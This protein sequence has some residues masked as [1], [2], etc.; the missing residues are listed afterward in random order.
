MIARFA[1]HFKP[2]IAQ[3]LGTGG[4]FTNNFPSRLFISKGYLF[5]G[6][7]EK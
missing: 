5:L 3:G 1:A 6:D 4:L 7:E 2:N